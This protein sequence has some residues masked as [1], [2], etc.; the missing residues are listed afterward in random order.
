MEEAAELGNYLPLSFKSPKEQEYIAFLWDGVE[1]NYTHGKYPPLP[2]S[3]MAES[4]AA[5]CGCVRR[6][7]LV[8]YPKP[9]AHIGRMRGLEPC[10]DVHQSPKPTLFE[11]KRGAGGVGYAFLRGR[12][13]LSDASG[14]GAGA[15][16]GPNG[17]QVRGRPMLGGLRGARRGGGGVLG[18]TPGRLT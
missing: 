4:P 14:G 16:R 5:A 9:P 3:H 10:S 8:S 18:G 13:G 6:V 1:T 15:L 17:A 12:R 2:L 7:L 11:G